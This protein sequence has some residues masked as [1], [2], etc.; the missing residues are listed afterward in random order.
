MFLPA[1]GALRLRR[2]LGGAARA[3]AAGAAQ[4]LAPGALD[5]LPTDG[6]RDAEKL[7][8]GFMGFM[9]IYYGLDMDQ[10]GYEQ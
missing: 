2:G 3:L 10:R 4:R 8:P 6:A 7:R 1:A 9:M 5:A